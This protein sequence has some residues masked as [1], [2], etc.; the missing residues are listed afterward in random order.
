MKDLRFKII[1]D[2]VKGGFDAAGNAVG[3]LKAKFAGFFDVSKIGWAKIGG[4]AVAAVAAIKTVGDGLRTHWLG[5]MS[6][7]EQATVDFDRKNAQIFRKIRFMNTE[8][9]KARLKES[10]ENEIRDVRLARDRIAREEEAQSPLE[11]AKDWV[12]KKVN[13]QMGL[14]EL[15]DN[16]LKIKRLDESLFSLAK[17]L[18]IVKNTKVETFFDSV[19]KKLAEIE[20]ADFLRDV[21]ENNP[22]NLV[23]VLEERASKAKEAMDKAMSVL[24]K[25]GATEIERDAASEAVD[26]WKKYKD[27][28]VEARK[29]LEDLNEEAAGIAGAPGSIG[30]GGGVDPYA[31]ALAVGL[32]KRNVG[33]TRRNRGDGGLTGRGGHVATFS[34]PAHLAAAV[35]S[36]SAGLGDTDANRDPL[37]LAMKAAQETRMK[38]N[39]LLERIEKKTGAAP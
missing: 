36:R 17:S 20:D 15:T 32:T 28:L 33:M 26:T 4:A 7:L 16:E 11:K 14:G 35:A 5:L 30:E 31:M 34:T 8:T 23:T 22:E 19:S 27:A 38:A 39:E 9:D 29:A 3:S 10:I 24:L 12:E 18:E 13:A 2:F 1:A 37:L 21:G 6:D 25:D